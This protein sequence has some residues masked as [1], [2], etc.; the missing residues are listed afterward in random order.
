MTSA[1]TLT[2]RLDPSWRRIADPAWLEGW[3][4][5]PLAIEGGATEVVV[6]GE[7]PTVVLVPPLP[8]HKETFAACAQPLARAHRVVTYDLRTRYAAGSRMA[9]AVADLGRVMDAHAAGPAVL[10]GHSL[11]GAIAQRFAL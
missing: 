10:V 8:G 3:V 11:G 5:Q 1:A 9:Q 6:Q 2:A 4:P 7:G